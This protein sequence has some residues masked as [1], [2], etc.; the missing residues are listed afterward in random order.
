MDKKI[1]EGGGQD[2]FQ[3]L[4]IYATSKEL[5]VS[6]ELVAIFTEHLS[7]LIEWF[8]KYFANDDVEKFAWIQ[9]PFHTQGPPDFT[10]Q[11]EENLIELELDS[12]V[13]I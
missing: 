9:D 13:R 11:E 6:Q 3:Q 10:S 5:I 1:N 4:Y 7:K 8:S 12:P 2:Y